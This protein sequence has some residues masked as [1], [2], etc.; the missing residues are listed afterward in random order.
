MIRQV[1][2]CARQNWIVLALALLITAV[3]SP[4][5]FAGGPRYITGTTY[6][7][8]ATPGQPIT[9]ANGTLTYY[10]DQ[11][12]LSP[13]LAGANA[14]SFVA[15]AFSRWT[16]VS[17]AA[18]SAVHDGQLAED[19]NGTNVVRNSDGTITMPADIQPSAAGT[20]IGIVYDYDGSVTNALLGAGA[21]DS[22]SCFQNAVFGGV[23]AFATSGNFAHALIVLNG[24]CIQVSTDLIES[25]YRLMRVLGRV[26]GLDWSQLNLNV[27][28]G[29]PNPPTA[30]DQAGFPLM[31][32]LDPTSCVP[33]TLCYPDPANLK[34]DDQAAISRLYPVTSANLGQFAGKQTLGENTAR[35]HGVVSFTDSSGNATQGMQAVNVVARWIDSS[36]GQPSHRY[37]ASA[38]SGF[39][40]RGNSGSPVSGWSDPTGVAYSAFGSVDPTLEGL[41]DLAGL[42]LP[43]G[44]SGQYQLHVEAIDPTWS[45]WMGPYQPNQVTPSGSFLPVVVS[46][47]N[48]ADIEQDAPMTGSAL[49]LVYDPCRGMGWNDPLAVPDSGQWSGEISG[50]GDADYLSLTAQANR[51][52]TVDAK[53]IDET[54]QPSEQKVRPMIGMWAL[55]DPSGTAAEAASNFPFDIGTLGTTRLSVQVLSPGALRI[56]VTDLRG[57]GRPDFRY[58]G[59]VL[60]GDSA[61]PTRLGVL[62]GQPLTLQGIGF[63]GGMSVTVGGVAAQ[64]LGASSTQMLLASPAIS[65][66]VQSIVITNPDTQASSSLF[67]VVTYGAAAT[68]QMTLTQSNPAI[69][70]GAQTPNPIRVTVTDS[71]TNLPVNGA[72]VQWTVNNGATL[73]LCNAAT[74]PALTDESGRSET[75]VTLGASGTTTVTAQLAPAAYP[76]KSVQ[77]T[78]T[79]TT[80]AKSISLQP[81][82]LWAVAGT[83]LN[84]PLAARVLTSAGQPVSGLTLNFSVTAGTGAVT[85]STVTTDSAGSASA[86]L[87]VASLSSE[88]DVVV[89][90]AGGGLACPA[91]NIYKVATSALQLQPVIGTQQAIPVGHSFSPLWLRV[92]D[93]SSPPNPVFGVPVNFNTTLF[94]PSTSVGDPGGGGGRFPVR[95]V[96]G[97]YQA[98]SVS[99]VDGY[100]GI[101]PSNGGG[102]RALD[103]EVSA[104]P[105][106]G[107][108]LQFSLQTLWPLPSSSDAESRAPNL[109][110]DPN[111]ALDSQVL[112]N[113]L[114][115][116]H[117][118]DYRPDPRCL[119][120]DLSADHRARRLPGN[121]P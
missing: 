94:L 36:S 68:D 4:P 96:V 98:T 27:I 97:A 69:P 49:D 51:T 103:V 8:S 92:L 66:S 58:T 76:N 35:I 26:L 17:T 86:T 111:S 87:S 48:G 5:A 95:V 70:V 80:A 74:C 43:A 55:S 46:V 65:D 71:G 72:T 47:A 7:T 40:F 57:D 53:A 21:G 45:E 83:A 67:N 81:I 117:E 20:P 64:V 112:P 39:L 38:V 6:F 31:H 59:H 54:G 75:R 62:G 30:D 102:T 82:R 109:A 18:L 118:E 84:V 77:T 120:V 121:P 107:A 91:L 3:L 119:G 37:S 93:S 79:S 2:L 19:V 60:Y 101:L 63:N 12:N 42:Q 85:P 33:I 56:G 13:I 61:S 41:F 24:N 16:S 73:S 22:S 23:D 52:L 105:G 100:S 104:D 110:P 14:D 44:T 106:N 9:W 11:G 29:V 32:A 1:L 89:C 34:M 25:K 115:V 28:T 108:G 116:A 114:G 78:L 90:A 99:T 15:D 10:T 50:Y 113:C 88:V